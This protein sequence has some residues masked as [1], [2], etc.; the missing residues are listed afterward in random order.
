VDALSEKIRAEFGESIELFVHTDGCMP[1]SCKL[2]DR[3]DCHVRLHAFEKK[4]SWNLDNILTDQKHQ[5]V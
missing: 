1:F 4:L 5:I 2:C 3:A